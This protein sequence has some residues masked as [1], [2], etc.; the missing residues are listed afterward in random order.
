MD[1]LIDRLARRLAA[2][3]SQARTPR[4]T[5]RD[6][7]RRSISGALVLALL[8]SRAGRASSEI[9]RQAQDRPGTFSRREGVER[10]RVRRTTNGAVVDFWHKERKRSG[11]VD[12][13]F[14]KSGGS[15]TAL[16]R[17]EHD[18][19]QMAFNFER[20]TFSIVD[21][22]GGSTAATFDLRRNRWDVDPQYDRV[23]RVAKRDVE[24]AMAI[25]SDLA[26]R[27]R[28]RPF[29]PRQEVRASRAG[30]Q[31]EISTAQTAPRCDTRFSCPCGSGQNRQYGADFNSARS[32]ACA[33]ANIDVN[34]KCTNAWC[35]GCCTFYGSSGQA[36]SP[37]A[38][39]DCDCVCAPGTD[40]LCRCTR[41]AEPCAGEC[42]C[43]GTQECCGDIWGGPA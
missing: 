32:L 42:T 6:V 12:L 34:Q 29:E 21:A 16:L 27:P 37:E 3:A 38:S 15:G 2:D 36:E 1:H 31:G 33:G 11:T 17:R 30:S 40:V 5:R 41:A 18:R 14:A 19:L 13:V 43:Y 23:M 8:G 22:D 28:P 24:I 26:P 25:Y 35:F 39:G 10:W 20:G 9:E 4:S 7:T